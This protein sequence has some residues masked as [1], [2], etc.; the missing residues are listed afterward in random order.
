M[1]RE[2]NYTVGEPKGPY[3]MLLYGGLRSGKT[4]FA[5]TWPRP[6][7]FADFVEGGYKTITDAMEPSDYYEPPWK[8]QIRG[9]KNH[10]DFI[11]ELTQLEADVK[12]GGPQ[13]PQTAVLDSLTFYGL[14]IEDYFRKTLVDEIERN[15]FLLWD[16]IKGH[17]RSLLIR[18][19]KLPINWIWVCLDYERGELEKGTLAR[20]PMITGSMGTFIPGAC[21]YIV[22]MRQ[23]PGKTQMDESKYYLHTRM[24]NHWPAGCRGKFPPVIEQPT[25]RRFMASRLKRGA[26]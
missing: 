23:E 12:K 7:I 14:G 18:A 17:L 1:S 2:I 19:H 24:W 22:R 10:T 21:D 20:G 13:A 6:R 8:P 26:K 3:T 4:R 15:K 5:A 9:L 16:K 25:Y 11:D